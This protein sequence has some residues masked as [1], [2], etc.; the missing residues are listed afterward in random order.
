MTKKSE[1]PIRLFFSAGEPSG[2]LHAAELIQQLKELDPT[3]EIVG[4]GGPQM[5]NAGCSLLKDLT[6]LAIMWLGRAL[7]NIRKFLRLLKDA[8]NYFSQN[9]V[10]AVI[11][12]D[13]PGFNW[14][15]AKRAKKH[16][17]P[18]FYFM[19]PQIW[20]WATWRIKKMRRLV[21]YVLCCLPFEYDWFKKQGCQVEYIGHPFFEEVRKRKLDEE[22]L[23]QLRLELVQDSD[24]KILTLLPGS[25]NQEVT[26]NFKDFLSIVQQ[27]LKNYPHVQPVVA[28]FKESQKEWMQEQL[29]ARGCSI[30]IY[31][32][33][34]P[35]LIHLADCCLGVSGS[36]SLELLANQRPA[37]IYYRISP[38]AYRLQQFF[39]RSRYITLVNLLWIDQNDSQDLFYTEFLA[40][41]EPS[42]YD[43]ARMVFPEFLTNRDQSGEVA[44]I[45]T[46]WLK[47]ESLLEQKKSQLVSVLEKVDNGESPVRHAGEF[48]LKICQKK[49]G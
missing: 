37:V 1:T 40:P 17:I 41:Y 11:L 28:A 46:S 44:A 32:G 19:P 31:V 39:R 21:D 29:T 27:V 18:V 14:L 45:L 10:D 8:D 35:E 49:N 36:V 24:R 25:R 3:V 4:Y 38:F 30:P 2:D 6:Q 5:Q 16:G 43:K 22:Q 34:T 9:K 15:I 42:V 47:D 13:Y 48:I 33:K 26:G 7:W 23:R 12:V 20:S